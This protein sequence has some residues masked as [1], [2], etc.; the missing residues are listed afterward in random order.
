M[1]EGMMAAASLAADA[2]GALLLRYRRA[3]GLTQEAL[4][5][6]A[7]L[8]ARGISD[9]ERGAR[10]LPR[11]D[12]LALLD[13]ALALAPGDRAALRAAAQPAPPAAPEGA[14]GLAP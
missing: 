12:T 5:E 8:S 2:F 11:H 10:R 13:A 6:R 3:A 4:A 7:G 1:R 14:A 9:L